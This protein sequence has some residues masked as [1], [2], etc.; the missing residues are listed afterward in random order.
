MAELF[1]QFLHFIAVDF[2]FDSQCVCVRQG[3]VL[4]A[5][6]EQFKHKVRARSARPAL[7]PTLHVCLASGDVRS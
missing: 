1:L 7:A 6:K 3:R 2:D 5:D 4:P